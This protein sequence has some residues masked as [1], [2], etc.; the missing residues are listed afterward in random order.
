MATTVNQLLSDFDRWRANPAGIVRAALQTVKDVTDGKIEIVDCSNPLVMGI[1]ACA[2]MTSAFMARNAIN[3]RNQYASVAQTQEEVNRH[4]SDK[5]FDG[6]YA[7]PSR[8]GFSI[9]LQKSEIIAKAVPSDVEGISK[10]V[11]PRN[12][13]FILNDDLIFSIQYPIEIRVLQHGGFRVVWNNDVL[14]PL[15]TLESNQV[16]NMA[17][18]NKGIDWL[19]IDIPVQQFNIVSR[20]GQLNSATGFKTTISIDPNNYYYYT[21]VYIEQ[22]D[23]TWKEIRTTQ[24]DKVYDP[25]TPT[26]VVNIEDGN[27]IV[28]VPQIYTTTGQ[29]QGGIRIDVYQTRGPLDMVLS[30]YDFSAF[31]ANFLALDSNEDDKY[32]A[33][34]KSLKAVAVFS[35]KVVAGGSLPVDFETQRM[36]VINNATAAA[37]PPITNVQVRTAVEVAGYKLV[38]D[39]DMLTNRIFWATRSLPA[40]A[41]GSTV[42]GAACSIENVALSFKQLAQLDSVIDNGARATITPD[43]LYQIKDGLVNFLSNAEIESLLVLSPENRAKAV[44]EGRYI[45]TPFHYVLDTTGDEFDSRPYYLDGPVVDTK[46][47]IE[48]NQS[49][50]LQV[51]TDS[52]E[53]L[54][55]PNGYKLRLKTTSS[56]EYKAL[57][58]D[59][60]HVQLAFIPPGE[61]DRAYMNG[62]L[63]STDADTKERVFEFDITSNFDVNSDNELSLLSFFLYNDSPRLTPTQLETEF[64][65]IWAT[66]AV[67]GDGYKPNGVD[68]ILG[69]YLLPDRI[70]GITHETVRIEFGQALKRL[71]ARSR[72]VISSIEYQKYEVDIPYVYDQDI[73][74][75]DPATGAAFTIVNGEIVYHYLHRKGDP[76]LDENGNPQIKFRAGV[77]IKLDG[78][79][80]PIPV[81]ERDMV[82]QI[83]V[84]FLEGAYWFA[85]ESTTTSYRKSLTKTLVGW[86]A[87][88]LEGIVQKLLEQ[89]KLYFHPQSALGDIDVYILDGL[90]TTIPA[91]QAFTVSLYVDANVYSDNDLRN[92]LKKIVTQTVAA[93]LSDSTVA[94]SQITADLESL[95]SAEVK[96]I[97]IDGLG[98]A[99][100]LDAL[101]VINEGYRCSIRKRLVARTD[102]TLAVEDDVTVDFIRHVAPGT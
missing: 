79:G 49:T 21:R 66:S 59:Q 6:I 34:M 1:E 10:L 98:G 93:R 32:V 52:Y 42:T 22:E 69:G 31:K 4:M 47:F 12:T 101:T 63:L 88:D 33:P 55:G 95:L 41:D 56:P 57:R 58:D 96:A 9:L 84:L 86:I 82:R 89:T 75:K 70:A 87:D 85:T 38:T 71:W 28:S 5:D 65:I 39:V 24:T 30:D 26:A 91:A 62:T 36:R 54:R 60:L 7:T 2:T 92:S 94:I 46:A 78:N 29:M 97:K 83:D 25:M 74:D 16:T 20:K 68:K 19:R 23:L 3:T 61:K 40:P 99:S 67:L 72:S 44:T 51:S 18:T 15:L 73:Y 43:T 13:Q 102:E 27:V 14:S 90:K 37:D 77:D 50:L 35:D 11:I 17:L 45:Y 100:D 48:E 76:V 81:D 80:M 53:I 64:D 8:A